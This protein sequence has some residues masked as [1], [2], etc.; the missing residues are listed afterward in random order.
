VS[1]LDN[2]TLC[3]FQ[4][5]YLG[6]PPKQALLV[7][8]PHVLTTPWPKLVKQ[9]EPQ[10]TMACPPMPPWWSLHEAHFMQGELAQ[11]GM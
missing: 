11:R 10:L 1:P 3:Y 6:F 9:V 2:L 5:T 8:K 7:P 4:T